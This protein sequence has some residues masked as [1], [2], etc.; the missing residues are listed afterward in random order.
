M[1]LDTNIIISAIKSNRID[2]IKGFAS[3]FSI[4][5]VIK[6][7]NSELHLENIDKVEKILKE[8]LTIIEVKEV[9]INFEELIEIAKRFKLDKSF[10]NDYLHLKICQK[11]NLNFLTKDKKLAKFLSLFPFI[12]II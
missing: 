12:H 2:S 4:F 7:L 5:E 8:K 10:I 1:Y 9:E 11:F 6:V 3:Y